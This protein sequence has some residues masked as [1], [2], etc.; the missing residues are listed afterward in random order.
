MR[1]FLRN[2]RPSPAMAVAFIALLAALSGTAT[3]LQGK[4]TVDSGDIKNGKVKT[5]DLAN[6][7]VTGK[8]IKNNAVTGSKVKNGSLSGTD[9][10]DNSLTG[11]NINESTLGQVP[12]A[13]TANS[14]NSANTANT[15]GSA[16]SANR[17]NSAASV[18]TFQPYSTLATATPGPN[19]TAAR[20]AAPEIA[21]ATRGA[22]T[23]Y[24]KCFTDTSINQVNSYTF[25]RTSVDGSVLD[26]DDNNYSGDEF[27]DVATLE[28]DRSIHSTDASGDS[29]NYYASHTAEWQAM[30][31]NGS[32]VVGSA[33]NG[34]KEGD[35][36]GSNGIYGAGDVCLF[37]GFLSG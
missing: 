20:L 32:A 26:S 1:R 33:G 36:P 8:K 24:G 12:S 4:N 9:I 18:D 34:A 17:A 35:L 11:T 37:S 28:D 7:A 30:A 23:I 10:K 5:K 22:F 3:A 25:I 14:A 15:A 21:L 2:P 19:F 6:G 16:G 29:A 31:P 13:N 27:L